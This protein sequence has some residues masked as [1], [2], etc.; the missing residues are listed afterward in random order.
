MSNE[1]AEVEK[2]CGLEPWEYVR[3][4]SGNILKIFGTANTKKQKEIQDKL[5]TFSGRFGAACISHLFFFAAIIRLNPQLFTSAY[6]YCLLP[7]MT[8]ICKI[9]NVAHLIS[10][11]GFVNGLHQL[12]P[13][14]L[15][16]DY[17]SN[18]SSIL[19]IHIIL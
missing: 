1:G 15:A 9:C 8:N 13:V 2:A 7:D 18:K 5:S 6:R 4:D 17:S 19:Y 12:L 16:Q 11:T 14:L 10:G 3:T